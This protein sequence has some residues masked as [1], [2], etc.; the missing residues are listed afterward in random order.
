MPI[1]ERTQQNN[2]IYLDQ[3]ETS[4][5]APA[6]IAAVPDRSGGLCAPCRRQQRVGVSTIEE[7]AAILKVPA[8]TTGG[9]VAQ[10]SLC[11]AAP[12]SGMWSALLNDLPYPGAV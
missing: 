7:V 3:A 9:C 4:R 2:E 10:A 11:Q 6:P 1:D 12:G 8:G 5:Q